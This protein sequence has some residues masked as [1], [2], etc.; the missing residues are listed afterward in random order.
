VDV[1]VAILTGGNSS[2]FGRIKQLFKVDGRPLFSICYE[3]FQPLSDDVF[4]QGEFSGTD[5][6]V[7][8]DLVS[9][10]GPLGGIYSAL[11][12]ARHERVFVLA[13]DMP[14]LDPRILGLLLEHAD[15][16]LVVPRWRNGHYEPLC[17]LYSKNQIS[18]VKDMLA[19]GSL[20]IS[21]LFGMVE[22]ASFPT[23]DEWIELGLISASCFRNM[24]ELHTE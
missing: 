19:S 18:L 14:D 22:K 6:E 10:H 1:S 23:I 20:K 16:D 7:R 21:D 2:R 13:C 24:N 3:K 11:K 4:L 8:T 17:S 15:S 9:E 12:N 5:T